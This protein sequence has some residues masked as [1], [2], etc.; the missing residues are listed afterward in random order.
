MWIAV[1][2]ANARGC[3]RAVAIERHPAS[4]RKFTHTLG[5]HRPAVSTDSRESDAWRLDIRPSSS[6]LAGV[7]TCPSC[8]TAPV[9]IR[10]RT[11]HSTNRAPPRTGTS[12]GFDTAAFV[13]SQRLDPPSE[14]PWEAQSRT[15]ARRQS[16]FFAR[17][18]VSGSDVDPAAAVAPVGV[19]ISSFN[20]RALGLVASADQPRK[21]T[22]LD[23]S[24]QLAMARSMPALTIYGV[25][26]RICAPWQAHSRP[27][28]VGVCS[29]VLERTQF[30]RHGWHPTTRECSHRGGRGESR[31]IYAHA[32]VALMPCCRCF[33]ARRRFPNQLIR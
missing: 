29:C 7:V 5:R 24:P 11:A 22:S 12:A 27:R 9:S 14:C 23:Q 31:S 33:R 19:R 16:Q 8:R 10:P 17:A 21:E 28:D 6:A 2:S 3:D 20:P 13:S 30:D 1:V 26:V 18:N 32:L 15:Q 4:T 25:T